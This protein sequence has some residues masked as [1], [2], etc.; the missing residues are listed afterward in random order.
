M[1][2][3][4]CELSEQG[5]KVC[6]PIHDALLVE[7]GF[8]DI[9]EVVTRARAEMDHASELVLGRGRIV[10]TDV[11]IVRYPDR[12]ADESGIDLWNRVMR[13]LDSLD[14]NFGVEK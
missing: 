13:L 10:R 14:E 1:R 6:A 7:A 3:A 11:E 12:Y 2:L 4:C 5:I 9:D 8:D